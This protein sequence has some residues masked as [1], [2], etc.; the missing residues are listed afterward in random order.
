MKSRVRPCKLIVVPLGLVLL[1]KT[2][3]DRSGVVY[4]DVQGI[5]LRLKAL[6]SAIFAFHIAYN[7][8]KRLGT[9]VIDRLESRTKYS[10]S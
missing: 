7:V 8:S 1:R 10:V 3:N 2:C 5:R 4:H 9:T 6:D